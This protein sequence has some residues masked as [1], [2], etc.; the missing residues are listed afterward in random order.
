MPN[1]RRNLSV[2]LATWIAAA[3]SPGVAS[4]QESLDRLVSEVI[5]YVAQR[6]E[7]PRERAEGD[8]R[9]MEMRRREE[10]P[11]PEGPAAG[12]RRVEI[13]E[14]VR[15]SRGAPEPDVR[16]GAAGIRGQI[17]S[18]D[19]PRRA[20]DVGGRELF[21]R[22]LDLQRRMFEELREREHEM[23]HQVLEA[24]EAAA[25]ARSQAAVLEARLEAAEERSHLAAEIAEL[26]AELRGVRESAERRETQARRA[27]PPAESEQVARVARREL[28]PARGVLER[29]HAELNEQA[30][31]LRRRSEAEQNELR[32]RVEARV[33]EME[34][35]VEEA[36]ARAEEL[37]EQNERLK[38]AL[39]ERRE[40][41][42]SA[43]SSSDPFGEF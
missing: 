15:R 40:R 12:P 19:E 20:D 5:Q 22:A 18:R 42:R 4:A 27:S 29:R 7:P 31:E 37:Q 39:E 32:K 13:R 34:R 16:R 30:R 14:E 25:E 11:R 8:P 2:I 1:F 43:E 9:R 35:A 17:G 26:H 28:E 33:G 23:M 10:R 24:R 21:E 36:R 3:A 6:E 41:D 38:R